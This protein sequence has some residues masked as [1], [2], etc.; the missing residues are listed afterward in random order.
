[1]TRAKQWRK[2]ARPAID[3]NGAKNNGEPVQETQTATPSS[4]RAVLEYQGKPTQKAHEAGRVIINA[5]VLLRRRR[6]REDKNGLFRLP[7][8]LRRNRTQATDAVGK[9]A[10]GKTASTT[11]KKS[12]AIVTS[13]E[14]PFGATTQPASNESRLHRTLDIMDRLYHRNKNQH[15]AQPWWRALG[16]LR[17]HVAKLCKLLDG[18]SSTTSTMTSAK[19]GKDRAKKAS[20]EVKT[21]SVGQARITRERLD[22]REDLRHGAEETKTWIR[23]VLITRCYLRFGALVAEQSWVNLGLVLIGVLGDIGSIVGLPEADNA[24]ERTSG[25]YQAGMSGR[26]EDVGELVAQETKVRNATERTVEL[27]QQDKDDEFMGFSDEAEPD[28]LGRQRLP[29]IENSIG[30]DIPGDQKGSWEEM[31]KDNLANSTRARPEMKKK[32]A[33]SKDY[34]PN[35]IIDDLFADLV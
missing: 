10:D 1:M 31:A 3:R 19:L 29:A 26:N 34:K 2:K 20:K 27:Q 16:L 24:A 4:Q 25:A 9:H 18:L 8:P 28:T 35:A 12:D 17:Y 13:T 32:R 21:G 30:E 5:R 11:K 33:R 22:H 6:R 15:R 14:L 7:R 23:E